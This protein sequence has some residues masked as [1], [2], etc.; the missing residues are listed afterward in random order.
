MADACLDKPF[1]AQQFAAA[2]EKVDDAVAISVLG[3]LHERY[4]RE[5]R[6]D[7]GAVIEPRILAGREKRSSPRR[8]KARRPADALE[9]QR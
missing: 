3:L 9:N 6:A 4:Y 5:T 1:T 2:I 7:L 8:D